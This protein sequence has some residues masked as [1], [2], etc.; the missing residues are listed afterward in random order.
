R[1]LLTHTDTIRVD[2]QQFKHINSDFDTIDLRFIRD[3]ANIHGDSTTHMYF[4]FYWPGQVNAI[5]DYME[6]MTAHVDSTDPPL[7]NGFG[8]AEPDIPTGEAGA[9]SG[10]D[11]LAPNPVELGK[12]V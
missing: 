5:F 6:L 11:F 12:L 7:T 10:E 3:S 4:S 9:F 8:G 1:T 2:T